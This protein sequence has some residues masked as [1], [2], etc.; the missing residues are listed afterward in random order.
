MV[1]D[2]NLEQR[3]PSPAAH[4]RTSWEHNCGCR[5]VEMASEVPEIFYG[6]GPQL[7]SFM[8]VGIS[9]K[10]SSLVSPVSV[11]IDS[12]VS[13]LVMSRSIS[14]TKLCSAASLTRAPHYSTLSFT[15]GED[16]RFCLYNTAKN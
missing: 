13:N 12:T 11:K 1:W 2:S 10:Y 16:T 8:A 5:A 3:A 9:L 4:P 14:L 15:Y 6:F 7:N